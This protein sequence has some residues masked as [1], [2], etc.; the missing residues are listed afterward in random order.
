[1]IS[2]LRL[3]R[4]LPL[5]LFFLFNVTGWVFSQSSSQ[6]PPSPS[7]PVVS[8]LTRLRLAAAYSKAVLAQQTAQAAQQTAQMALNEWNAAKARAIKDEKLPEGTVFSVDL[9]KVGEDEVRAVLPAPA[10]KPPE[11]A[12]KPP[13]PAPSPASVPPPASPSGDKKK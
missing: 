6:P 11:K 7:A 12:A 9:S 5:V 10:A 4:L 2:S 8:E 13:T 3:S 1:M